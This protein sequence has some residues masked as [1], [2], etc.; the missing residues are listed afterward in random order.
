MRRWINCTFDV[1][2]DFITSLTTITSFTMQKKHKDENMKKDADKAH[3]KRDL[4]SSV[5]TFNATLD[6]IISLIIITS[7]SLQKK[8]TEKILEKDT[9]LT[10][11]DASAVPELMFSEEMY[12]LM[13]EY[14]KM[15]EPENAHL[16]DQGD[17]RDLQI[18]AIPFAGSVS[19]FA[20]FIGM[21]FFLFGSISLPFAP[22]IA[23]ST[24][25]APT[26]FTAQPTKFSAQPSV[27]PLFLNAFTR[28]L[29]RILELFNSFFTI[30]A[31]TTIEPTSGPSVSFAPSPTPTVSHAPTTTNKPSQK[32]SIEPTLKPTIT[33]KPSSKPSSKPSKA[34]TI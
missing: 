12:D 2:F 14:Y 30:I 28:T 3:A 27:S 16:V 6:F 34:P 21:Y 5:R 17:H 33:T 32:P 10:V 13:M 26:F 4:V 11:E 23:P 20:W 9:S 31:D 7:L 8:Q 19:S 18:F 29:L 25:Q 15:A 22:S 24:T 1:T